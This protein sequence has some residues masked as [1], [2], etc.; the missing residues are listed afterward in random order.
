M[1]GALV[2]NHI[3]HGHTGLPRTWYARHLTAKG[4]GAG[5]AAARST[6]PLGRILLV[7]DEGS[8][9]LAVSTY[10]EERGFEVRTASSAAEGL[11]A[12]KTD[13]PECLITD[14]SMPHVDGYQL[15]LQVKIYLKSNVDNILEQNICP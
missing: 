1:P 3:F 7:D 5:A 14:I 12:I 8:L 9:L 10:L 11:L 15:L 2:K 4:V 6:E 13:P